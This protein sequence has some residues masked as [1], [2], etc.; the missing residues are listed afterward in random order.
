MRPLACAAAWR[1]S[2][3]APASAAAP[4][5]TSRRDL[6]RVM[7]AVSVALQGFARRLRREYTACRLAP[8]DMDRFPDVRQLLFRPILDLHD[9][10][11]LGRQA[12]MEIDLRSQIGD[13]FHGAGKGIVHRGR[14]T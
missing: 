3:A 9:H 6:C 11:F 7:M 4:S 2:V 5:R 8:A 13:E 12:D 14:R 1:G 10:P